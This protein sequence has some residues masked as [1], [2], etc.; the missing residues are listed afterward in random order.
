MLRR[1]TRR[2]SC[3][4]RRAYLGLPSMERR[5]GGHYLYLDLHNGCRSDHHSADS[6]FNRPCHLARRHDRASESSGQRRLQRGD[7]PCH[8]QLGKLYADRAGRHS[9]TWPGC[10][11][12]GWRYAG[13]HPVQRSYSQHNL[14]GHHHHRRSR[15]GWRS[16]G[17]Q[18]CLDLHDRHGGGRSFARTGFD[19]PGE[20]SH[21]RA[22]QSGSQRSVQ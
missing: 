14:Y 8:H 11:R 22:P 13:L 19:E 1:L 12:S 7:G 2:P 10:L 17:Q 5:R 9:R 15:P 6:D 16:N 4:F 20:R 18:I 3:W 21:E